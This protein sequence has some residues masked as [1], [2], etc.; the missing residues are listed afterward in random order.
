MLGW[1]ELDRQRELAR[2]SRSERHAEAR[3]P[4]STRLTIELANTCLITSFEASAAQ[5]R[6]VMAR[7]HRPLGHHC[8]SKRAFFNPFRRPRSLT[9]SPVQ[10]AKIPSGFSEGIRTLSCGP[11]KPGVRSSPYS[12]A[13]RLQALDNER[14]NVAKPEWLEYRLGRVLTLSKLSTIVSRVDSVHHARTDAKHAR[15]CGAEPFLPP[16]TRSMVGNSKPVQN[17]IRGAQM[18]LGTETWDGYQK[19]WVGLNPKPAAGGPSCPTL[20]QPRWLI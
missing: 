8:V 12:I 13:L 3:G 9:H 15:V 18:R 5:H 11:Q 16:T 7:Q 19:D 6:D 17:G 20:N 2:A 14:L 1:G 10:G 4:Y